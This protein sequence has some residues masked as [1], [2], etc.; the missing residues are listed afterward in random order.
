MSKPK[1]T[2]QTENKQVNKQKKYSNKKHTNKQKNKQKLLLENG[3]PKLCNKLSF[4][5]RTN[6]QI[7]H[8]G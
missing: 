3:F 4:L 5:V 2:K 1:I 6:K 8:K 7:K